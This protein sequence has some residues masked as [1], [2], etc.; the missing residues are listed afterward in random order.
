M[1]TIEITLKSMSIIM[2][3][4]LILFV[5][6]SKDEDNNAPVN[7]G[8]RIIAM[9]CVLLDTLE[10]NESFIYNGSLLSEIIMPETIISDSEKLVIQYAGGKI[11]SSAYFSK[12]DNTW[13]MESSN[14]ILGYNG[15]NP[16]GIHSISYDSSGAIDYE[17]KT[18]YTYSGTLL[19]KSEYY[20][21]PTGTWGL[22]Y[23]ILYSYD[24][25]GRIIQMTDTT[26]KW[27]YTY[28]DITRYYYDGNQLK[29][30]LE[31]YYSSG[32]LDTNSKCTYQ[33]ANNLLTGKTYYNWTG[34]WTLAS[35]WQYG[36]NEAGNLV[37]E[38]RADGAWDYQYTYGQGTGNYRQC[39]KAF[40]V[41]AIMPGDPTPYPVKPVKS[42]G[43]IFTKDNSLRSIHR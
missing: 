39:M 34:I 28:G 27:G 7:N 18:L 31:L 8:Q 41:E 17:S 38:R 4:C 30:T 13:S 43:S 9:K 11:S 5:G 26:T 20:T 42:K 40:D 19:S 21:K 15:D 22:S 36:Y 29:E 3:C 33:Y 24:N 37:S 23:S 6:C 2:V 32:T 16:S 12:R 35:E 25:Q 14:E 10:I 1:K